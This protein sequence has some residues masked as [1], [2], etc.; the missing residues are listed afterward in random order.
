MPVAILGAA[1][2]LATV[3]LRVRSPRAA[4][5]AVTAPKAISAVLEVIGKPARIAAAPRRPGDQLNTHANSEKARTLLGYI[6]TTTLRES[7]QK[8]VEWYEGQILG[9]I[10]L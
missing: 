10:R 5:N 2:L 3:V 6:P 9:R 7:V 4:R 1:S 8:T